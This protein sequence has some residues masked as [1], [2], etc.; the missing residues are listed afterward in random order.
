MQTLTVMDV[1]RERVPTAFAFLSGSYGFD[2]RREDDYAFTASSPRCEI[3][4][5]LDWGSVVLTLKPVGYEQGVRLAFIVGAVNQDIL[6][7]PRYPWGPD[8]ALDEI[9]RQARLL[10]EYC[11]PLLRG[12]FSRWTALEAHQQSVL[13]EWRRE[14][15]RLVSEAR[16][17]L[18]R[19]RAEGAYLGRSYAEA[20]RLYESIREHLSEQDRRRL[21]YAR[22]RTILVAVPRQRALGGLA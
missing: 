12:D 3:V 10:R 21:E 8:E 6:F 19:K 17:K 15:E 11:E 16:V 20:A 7:L 5:E 18:V 9:E 13:D 22:R 1:F 4:I 2:L 14:S